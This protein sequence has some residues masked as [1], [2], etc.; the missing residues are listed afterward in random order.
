MKSLG[1]KSGVNL[2]GLDP[3]Y[4]KRWFPD[5]I[6]NYKAMNVLLE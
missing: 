5:S 1:D 2:T 3:G 4:Y 6:G